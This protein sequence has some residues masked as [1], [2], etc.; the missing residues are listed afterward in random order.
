MTKRR[1][2][3]WGSVY[4]CKDGQSPHLVIIYRLISA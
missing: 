3:G 4:R 2:K 1:V